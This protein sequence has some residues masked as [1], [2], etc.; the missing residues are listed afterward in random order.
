M[1]K[2]PRSWMA[3]LTTLGL[4]ITGLVLLLSLPALWISWSAW[5]F[6]GVVGLG[7]AAGVLYCLLAAFD[8]FWFG[9]PRGPAAAGRT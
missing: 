7:I 4:N 3:R 6:V 9:A 2:T 5:V 1:H 8:D